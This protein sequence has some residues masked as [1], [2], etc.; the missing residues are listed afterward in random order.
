M[1]NPIEIYQAEDGSTQVEVRFENENVW[2]SQA[3]MAKIFET[4]TDNISLHL[5][6]IFN[7]KELEENRTTKDFS[8]VRLEGNRKVTRQV[9]HYNLDAIISVGYRVK[10]KSATQFRIWA[11]TRL[12]DY[13]T[14]GYAI[15]Q[16]RLQQNAYELEQAL[17]LIQKTANSSELTIESG[18][19]L[20][21]IVSRYTH[22]FLWLQQYDEGL[23][24]E[25]KVQVGGKLPT[26]EQAKQ[27][28]HELKQQ[29]MVRGEASELFGLER[30]NGLSAILG[31]LEQTVFGEP[32]YPILR[33]KQHIYS[34][35][36][37]K[38]TRLLME[39]NEVALSYL[40]IFYIEINA[41]LIKT[42]FRLLTIL[43]LL[44]SHY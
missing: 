39:I 37:S 6:N 40:S 38:I 12:K 7:E 3:Q 29:L 41:Y 44:H 13:L 25:P 20:V 2:L 23:L 1:T 24:I 42:I 16:K 34:T 15:N 28:L 11:T 26:I 22:T 5:K 30:D 10:S 19:G 32:A 33:Q 27:A 21:D 36:S 17:A 9:K 8:V 18:R 31:N 43:G 35:L 14:K 4:S